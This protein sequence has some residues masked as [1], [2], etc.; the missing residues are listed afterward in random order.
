MG[1]VLFYLEN[2]MGV[3]PHQKP[4]PPV[5]PHPDKDA[6]EVGVAK[7]YKVVD[8]GTGSVVFMAT[9]DPHEIIQMCCLKN[10]DL[11]SEVLR[12]EEVAL[13]HI[14]RDSV[15][16]VLENR[17]DNLNKEIRDKESELAEYDDM[18]GDYRNV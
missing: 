2:T 12:L 14:T 4:L 18:L 15:R 6:S 1:A 16:S 7:Y 13:P 3:M 17:V 5:G 11:Y 9:G 10:P 8:K